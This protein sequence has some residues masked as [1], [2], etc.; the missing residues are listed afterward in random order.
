MECIAMSNIGDEYL[1]PV[2]K[3]RKRN[4]VNNPDFHAALKE[5]K[6]VCLTHETA[7]K[8]LPPIPNY[9]GVCI[10]NMS[11][12]ISTKACFSNY[13]F[14][15]DMIMDAVETCFKYIDRFDPEKSNNPFAYFT[16][17]IK[18]AFLQRIAKEKKHL[19]V[20]YKNSQLLYTS[21]DTYDNGCINDISLSHY[22]IDV[23]HMNRFIEEYE[24]KMIEKKAKTKENARKK[25][26]ENSNN[27]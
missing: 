8:Q 20:K 23:D 17:V 10:M 24:E 26:D 4:Y 13:P 19:Y 22:T 18:N 14:K 27:N 25:A 16:T 21:G 15:E 1:E 12:R 7:G 11:T 6:S 5:Y 9:I 2:V 3:K